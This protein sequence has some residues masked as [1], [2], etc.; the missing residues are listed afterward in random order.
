[1]PTQNLTVRSLDALKPGRAR[2]EVFDAQT[3]GLAI[4]CDTEPAQVVGALLPLSRTPPPTD[5]RPL[6]RSKVRLGPQRSGQLRSCIN[7]WFFASSLFGAT[8]IRST[9]SSISL[10]SEPLNCA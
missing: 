8:K 6:S 3:Q 9:P 5:A 4:R 2:Y 7:N 10:R 1:M